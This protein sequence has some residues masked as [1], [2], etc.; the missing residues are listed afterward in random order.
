MS[1]H[2]LIPKPLARAIDQN[3]FLLNELKPLYKLAIV[4]IVFSFLASAF[5]GIGIGLLLSFLQSLTSPDTQGVST[6]VSWIDL[7]VLG[8]DRS[9]EN[10]LIRIS[11][12]IFI[13]TW[14]R[15]GGDYLQALTTGKVELK[16]LDRLR[17]R[18]FD[19]L[20]RFQLS[21]FSDKRS[22]ET[23]SILTNEITQLRNL[24]S[25]VTIL[26]TTGTRVS[27]YAVIICWIS[28]QLFLL[29]IVSLGLLSVGLFKFR[30][31][32][33]QASIAATRAKGTLTAIGI[34]FLSGI[35]TVH[36]FATQAYERERYNRAS[37]RVSDAEIR[38]VTKVSLLSPLT[39][40]GGTTVMIVI[41]TLGFLSLDITVAKLLVFVY[42]LQSMVRLMQLI[43]GQIGRVT[44][45]QGSYRVV[46]QLLNTKD[47]PYFED[48]N[49]LFPGLERAIEL[50]SINFSYDG[51]SQTLSDI[52]LTI[53]KGKTTALVG[54]SGS[55][56]STLAALICRFY[57]PQSGQ[58]LIDGVDS[59]AFQIT[60]L[61]SKIAIVSQETFIFNTSVRENIIYGL[62]EVEDEAIYQAAR[63][64]HALEFIEDMPEGFDTRLGDRGV[65]RSGGQRQRI[66]IARALLRNPE[67]LILD[68]A[69]SAL[70]SVSERLIQESLEKLSVNRTVIA[71]AH[72]L[73]TVARADKIVVLERGK[74]VEQGL[75]D[76]LLQRKGKLWH[77]HQVQFAQAQ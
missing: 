75:Y 54:A 12:L 48:G 15:S 46:K 7:H 52:N 61:R 57:D 44:A 55:G 37:S 53:E 72:R 1:R 41:I 29:S 17:R 25:A 22:G 21:Y 68:E 4:A 34:E 63:S 76:D 31:Y 59:Q 74:I 65:K 6:G 71:I 66:A 69:T 23:V 27:I 70:D 16:L 60:S 8:T 67:I 49:R 50:V 73:S 35:F 64:S 18:A 9:Q 40:G 51:S 3:R 10:Q 28:W 20:S 14:L 2:P 13:V 19:Q 77:Y 33:R 47:K 38:S 58:I 62:D 36:A 26:L 5:E 32:I 11:V 42:V 43:H 39:L 56:K 24:F 30:R 45:L